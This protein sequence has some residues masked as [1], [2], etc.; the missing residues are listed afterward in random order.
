MEDLKILSY[1]WC[2]HVGGS[3]G[4]LL[5]GSRVWLGVREP[6]MIVVE[7]GKIKVICGKCFMASFTGGNC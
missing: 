3:P 4:S 2:D 1:V 5:D 7:E 6:C